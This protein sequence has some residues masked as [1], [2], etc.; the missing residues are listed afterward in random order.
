V[1]GQPDA[2]GDIDGARTDIDGA[3][4]AAYRVVRYRRRRRWRRNGLL[5]GHGSEGRGDEE[6]DD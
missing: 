4:G 1:Y 5:C 2:A 6:R 3:N